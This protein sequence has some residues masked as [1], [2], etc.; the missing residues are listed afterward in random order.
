MLLSAVIAGPAIRGLG[1]RASMVSMSGLPLP[2]WGGDSVAMD[3][4]ADSG[5]VGPNGVVGSSSTSAR[6]L[7]VKIIDV[8]DADNLKGPGRCRR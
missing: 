1:V 8:K 3:S 5:K 7:V 4:A 6:L 2:R